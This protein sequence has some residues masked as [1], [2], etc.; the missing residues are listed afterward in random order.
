MNGSVLALADAVVM[1]DKAHVE[2]AIHHGHL[3]YLIIIRLLLVLTGK[4][5]VIFLIYS[6]FICRGVH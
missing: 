2:A 6:V 4:N 1:L 3:G 5:Q